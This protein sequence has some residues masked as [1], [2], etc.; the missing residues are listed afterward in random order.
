MPAGQLAAAATEL[1]AREGRQRVVI[2]LA[3]PVDAS[4]RAALQQR[5]V[6]LLDPL[7]AHAWFARLAPGL[8]TQRLTSGPVVV[9]RLEAIALDDKLHPDLSRGR[10][11]PWMRLHQANVEASKGKP[12]QPNDDRVAVYVRFHKDVDLDAEAPAVLAAHAARPHSWVRSIRTAVVHLQPSA[13]RALAA[14][15][16]V[17]YVEPPLPALTEINDSNRVRVG[18][19][20][21]NDP[22]YGLDGSGVSVLVYDGGQMFAHGDF[23]GRLTIGASDT[24]GISDHATHV[25]GTIGGDGSGSGGTHRGMAPGV[26]LVSYGFEQPG[27]LSEGF[28]YTD[29]GD[30]EAD[31]GEAINTYGVDLSNN[32]IGT[33]TAPNGFPCD[34]EGN[35]GTTGALIDSI[36]AGGLGEPFRV[37]WANGNERSSGRCGSTYVTTAPPAC[38]KNHITVGAMN[39]N[40]DSVTGFTSW[41][42]CDDGRIKPD[43]SGPGC[44]SGGDGGVTSTSSSGGYNVKCGTSMAS[45]T[46]AGVA[47]LLLQQYRISYPGQPDFRNATLKAILANTAVDLETPGPDYQT[48]YGSVRAQPAAETIIDGR[49]IEQSVAQGE[50]YT[51]LVLVGPEDSQLQ[52]TMAWDD[53]P[54]TPNVDPVLVNDLDLRV[55][56]PDSSVYFPWTLD[57][58][59][60]ADPAV[61]TGRDGV[62]NIEQVTIETPAP[63]VYR[64]EVEGFNIAQGPTQSFGAAASPSLVNCSNSG[65]VGTDRRQVQCNADLGLQVIDCDLNTDNGAVEA[66][67][68]TVAS[69]SQPAGLAVSLTETAAETA[70]FVGTLQ[71]DS[72]GGS[73][74]LQVAEG[75]TISVTYIDADDGAGGINVPVVANVTVDCS[76]PSINSVVLGTINP[77]DAEVSVGTDEPARVTVSYGTD[78]A[79]LDQTAVAFRLETARTLLLNGLQ[80]DTTYFFR[81]DAEDEA[82]N[83]VSDD[84][85][86]SCYS[87]TT[88]MVPD[89]FTEQFSAGLDLVGQMLTFVP[90]GATIDQYDAC[91]EP[92]PGGALPT[93]PAGGTALALADDTPTSFTLNDGATVELYGQSYGT[94]HV[95][96][97]GY[98]TFNDGDS[99]YSES[100]SAHFSS[101]RVAALFDDLNPT[102]SGEIS[103][104]QLDDRVAITWSDV[105]EYSTTNSNDFQIELFFDGTIR[106]SWL[107]IDVQDAIVGLSAG[108]GLDPDFLAS[109]LSD[110]GSCGPRPPVASDLSVST[111]VDVPVD[112]PL[113]VADDGLPGPLQVRIVS[114]PEF[115]SLTDTGTG[116]P[117]QTLPYTL[118][119]G[120]N[121][122]TYTPASGMSGWDAFNFQADDSGVAPDGGTSSIATAAISIGNGRRSVYEFLVDDTDPGWSGTGQW[123]FGIPQGAGSHNGDPSSGATGA[124]VLGYDLAGDYPNSMAEE[125]LT[126][127]PLDLST[128]VDTRIEFQRW[129]GVESSSY[130]HAR[131]EV[132]VDGTNWQVIWDHEGAALSANAWTLHEYD[133]ASI[134]DGQPTVQ[135]RWVMGT[136]DGS[137]TYPGWNLDDIRIT[138]QSLGACSAAPAEASRLRMPDT[139]TM[140]WQAAPY[141]GGDAP[142]YDV[143]RSAQVDDFGVVATCLE[144]ADGGDTQAVDAEA[145]AVGA[146][147]YYLIRAENQCG[148]G[149]LGVGD[150]QERLGR[151]C[152]P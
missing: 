63:G 19:E 33:N 80:D 25:G 76:A 43:V 133:V 147:Y 97:N 61:Q 36:V 99:S 89:F 34:W 31:Y 42:P 120:S 124:N 48:G 141:A 58:A 110:S 62:N 56:G 7:G 129:L 15:D 90:N 131:F 13:I 118:N 101:P 38:A 152:A 106:L 67:S 138:A 119:G 104:R 28:L 91:V 149:S 32:S 85:G 2:Q 139:Q 9:Q 74:V 20:I 47:A 66:A 10:I 137:V 107:Q 103:W 21:V 140:I 65:V 93:D 53:A 102:V 122:V 3:G 1:A 75:D 151:S 115:G 12:V 78:C 4:Q 41:G 132:S 128:S 46:V 87:F 109:D 8:D 113:P 50:T 96:M 71:V 60:P 146:L 72:S 142:V 57:P 14:E 121:L 17:M 112:L 45:P 37:V 148:V 30:I 86:G 16:E 35:Y 73:G 135:L 123:A 108:N 44:E 94:V 92:L 127:N 29:P 145:P 26:D 144:H 134:I 64:V 18:A 77:R 40:D 83:A 6:E 54:G 22:P 95:G 82:G 111:E 79:A 27:G 51:F 125:T 39:S 24:S 98:V 23:T 11:H 81:V 114:L 117:I 150:G 136:T 55:I 5:G 49:F 105:A 68:V 69:T 130:D 84:N 100:F 52:V 59:N 70:A 126:S 143:L 88:P 116:L